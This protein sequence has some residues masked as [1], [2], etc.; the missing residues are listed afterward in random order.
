MVN[1]LRT[2]IAKAQRQIVAESID[3]VD[4]ETNMQSQRISKALESPDNS[5]SNDQFLS[6]VEGY[7]LSNHEERFLKL[8]IEG[9]TMEEITNIL[10]ESAYRMRQSLQ[11]KLGDLQNATY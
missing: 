9:L 6:L 11:V 1:T 4:E 10:G 2:L 8:R 5:T 7:D 3:V